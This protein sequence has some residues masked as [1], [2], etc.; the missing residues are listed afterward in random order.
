MKIFAYDTQP[1]DGAFITFENWL[2]VYKNSTPLSPLKPENGTEGPVV[3]KIPSVDF[4][5]GKR[6]FKAEWAKCSNAVFELRLDSPDGE[7]IGTFITT[8]TDFFNAP[9][10]AWIEITKTAGLHDVYLVFQ[11]SSGVTLN[12]FEFTVHSPYDEAEYTP[13]TTPVWDCNCDTWEATDMLGRKV[14]SAEECP[15]KREK[16]IGMFYN[17]THSGDSGPRDLK[18]ILSVYPEAEF[19]VTHHAWEPG[20]YFWSEPFFGYYRLQDTYVL[21]KQ[22]I[23]L[24]MAGVDFICFD[25][26][27]GGNWFKKNVLAIL[28]EIRKCRRDGI[29]VPGITFLGRFGPCRD[30]NCLMHSLYQDIYKSGLYSDC[31][32]MLDGK[33][34]MMVYPETVSPLNESEGARKTAEEISNFFTFRPCQA[35]YYAGPTR[36]DQWSWLEVFPQHK[37]GEREDGTCEQMSVGVAQN[38]YE[39]ADSFTY[40]NYHDQIMMTKSYTSKDRTSKMTEDSYKYGYNFQEQWDRVHEVDPDVVYVTGWNEWQVGKHIGNGAKPNVTEYDYPNDAGFCDLFDYE[41]SRDIEFDKDGYLDTYFLQLVSNVRKFKGTVKQ[42]PASAPVT[43][44]INGDDSQWENVSPGYFNFKGSAPHRDVHGC[45]ERTRYVNKT[46]RNDITGSK[47]ARDS[48]Y[49]YFTATCE[50]DIVATTEPNCMELY[51]DIDRNRE[52]GWEGYDFRVRQSE[53][54]R[55][56]GNVWETVADITRV[57]SGNRVTLKIAKALLDLGEKMDFEFKWCDNTFKNPYPDNHL[58]KRGY[59]SNTGYKP[60]VMDFYKNGVSAPVGRFNYRYTV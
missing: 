19:D 10:D 15:D 41:R 48:E 29:K 31:W 43:I 50:N 12:W 52:T 28:N 30:S 9:S 27:N 5:D 58:Y 38:T 25:N 39:G 1:Y 11:A 13:V 18:D 49:M 34:L 53:L 46:G 7:T 47:V 56:N 55:F 21:R 36:T 40:F 37:F 44:N 8:N 23:L 16:F 20:G 35:S 14:A 26:S 59:M 54:Q 45:N 42:A 6:G 22:L 57:T 51:I 33:P 24:T 2:K 32:F 3:V 17:H 4:C 60:D